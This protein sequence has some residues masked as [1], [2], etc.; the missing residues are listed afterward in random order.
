MAKRYSRA[1]DHV[2]EV[3]TLEVLH[4][5]VRAAVLELADVEDARHVLAAQARR[6]ASL[7]LEPAER[8]GVGEGSG[9]EQLD[10]DALPERFVRGRE[11]HA[12]AAFADGALHAVLPRE[13][14]AR[15]HRR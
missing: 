15:G 4:H 7:A 5:H 14:H 10:G 12:H 13:H 1:T 3:L 9:T 8:L 6:G 2:P 11:D